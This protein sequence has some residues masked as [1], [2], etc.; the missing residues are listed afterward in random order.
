MLGQIP[1]NFNWIVD[2]DNL[3]CSTTNLHPLSR[4]QLNNNNWAGDF[5]SDSVDS[6]IH[7][8]SDWLL[9]DKT[10]N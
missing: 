3:L 8:V 4:H 9:L 2:M 10:P 6:V 5:E 1:E 7:C